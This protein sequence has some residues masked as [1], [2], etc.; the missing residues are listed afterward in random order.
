[1]S[2]PYSEEVSGSAWLA[3]DYFSTDDDVNRSVAGTTG[4]WEESDW[5]SPELPR[6]DIKNESFELNIQR[7]ETIPDFEGADAPAVPADTF[8]SS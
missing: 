6:N 8:F 3:G 2:H 5:P 4:R 1:M 7:K